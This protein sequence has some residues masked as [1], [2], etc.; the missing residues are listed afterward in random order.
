MVDKSVSI[1]LTS[2]ESRG[3]AGIFTSGLAAITTLLNIDYSVNIDRLLEL[4]GD[5]GQ[6]SSIYH[7]AQIAALVAQGLSYALIVGIM[8]FMYRTWSDFNSGRVSI[9][10]NGK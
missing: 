5:S 2:K 9:K 3:A 7:T 8:L 6:I 1:P 4:A 10:S